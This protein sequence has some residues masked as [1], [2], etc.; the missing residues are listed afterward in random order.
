MTSIE[1][2]LRIAVEMNDVKRRIID[3]FSARFAMEFEI[4]QVGG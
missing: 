4:H 1:K 3:S 2:E